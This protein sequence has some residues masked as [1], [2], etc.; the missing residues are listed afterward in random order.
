MPNTDATA[1]WGRCQYLVGLD[2]PIE[3][4]DMDTGRITYVPA[5]REFCV[6]GHYAE[7]AVAALAAAPPWV[8]KETLAGVAVRPHDCGRCKCFIEGPPVE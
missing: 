1:R 2:E 5:N 4:H 8:V 6:W 7:D 3:R